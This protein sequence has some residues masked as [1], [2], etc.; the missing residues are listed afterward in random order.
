MEGQ[1][2]PFHVSWGENDTIRFCKQ[3][4]PE[5]VAAHRAQPGRVEELVLPTFDHFWIHID[6]P[7]PRTHDAERSFSWM[8]ETPRTAE[9]FGA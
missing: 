8:A 4:A 5:F 1:Q 9:C 7:T 2:L 3:P 6:Q